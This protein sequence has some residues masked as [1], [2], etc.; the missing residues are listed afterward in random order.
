MKK[1]LVS[2][3][4]PEECLVPFRNHYEFTMPKT[5]FTYEEVLEKIA[6]YN[7]Y[8][9]VGN[10]ADKKLLDAGKK[11]KVVA[12][13]GVGYD[14]IDWQ[15]ATEKGI[16]VVNTPNKVTEATAEH[17][18]VLIASSMRGVA[19]YDREV[20]AGIW[21]APMFSDID[22]EI[23]GRTLGIIGFGRIGK[24][25]CQKAQGLGMNVVYYDKFRA[26]EEIEKE[27][28]VEYYPF[29]KVLEI[30]D[31]ITLH[32]PAIPQNYKLFEKGVFKKMKKGAYLVNTARGSIV[33]EIALAE[34]LKTG[35]IKGAGLDVFENEP[36]VN[37]ELLKLDNVI[38]TPH[39]A[40]C[41]MKAR[42]GMAHEALDG[43]VGVLEG[44]KPSNVVN[45]PVL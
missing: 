23:A 36:E 30:S 45:S 32:M 33:D 10:R 13:F 4:V 34:A 3:C 29:D 16:A 42:L 35:T 25:V 5:K 24:T 27:Y 1:I 31:C 2:Q 26:S 21:N 17:A 40:S 38:L 22:T 39:I 18:V 37:P 14:N 12:N 44:R 19:R 15:Y 6:E 11:L 8:F 41:T 43:I 7:A 9:I 28:G 20:R